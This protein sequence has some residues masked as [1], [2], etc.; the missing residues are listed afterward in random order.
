[1]KRSSVRN[2]GEMLTEFKRIGFQISGIIIAAFGGFLLY[3]LVGAML[4]K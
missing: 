4:A 1:M 2:G 3:V